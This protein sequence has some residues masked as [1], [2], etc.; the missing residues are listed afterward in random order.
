[1]PNICESEI[2]ATPIVA[3]AAGTKLAKSKTPVDLINTSLERIKSI[4]KAFIVKIV[5]VSDRKKSENPVVRFHVG[6]RL[7]DHAANAA[8]NIHCILLATRDAIWM[9]RHRARD[10]ERINNRQ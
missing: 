5:D 6:Q 9:N 1:V 2:G 3:S 7:L 8:Q 4:M 10:S